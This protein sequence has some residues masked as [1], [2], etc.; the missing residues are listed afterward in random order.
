MWSIFINNV[1]CSPRTGN[2]Y[3]INI[4]I[5]SIIVRETLEL[6]LQSYLCIYFIGVHLDNNL[7][8][9]VRDI[10]TFRAQ[11]SIYHNIGGLH[12]NDGDR[13]CFIQLY[14]YD[15]NHELQNKMLENPQLHENVVSKLQHILHLHNPFVHVFR[16]LA[17]RTNVHQ[18]SLNIKERPPNQSQYNLPNTSQVAAIIVVGNVETMI[19]GRD[20]KVTTHA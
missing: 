9:I 13:P 15:T 4:P 16:Q 1:P 11:G 2:K 5:K 6:R 7:A 14:I 17:L 19:N 8:T 20:I 3:E 18:C 10:Y 12:P